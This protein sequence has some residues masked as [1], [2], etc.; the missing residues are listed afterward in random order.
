MQKWQYV[1]AEGSAGNLKKLEK[2][3]D[4]AG[5]LGWEAVGIFGIKKGITNDTA[6]VLLKKPKD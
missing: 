4:E 2:V 3:L 5:E 6:A 1:F